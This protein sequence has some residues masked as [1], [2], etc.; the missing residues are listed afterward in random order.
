VHATDP[1][2]AS[3]TLLYNLATGGWD[4]VL[5]G[6]FGVP[7]SMLPGVVPSSGVLAETDADLFGRAVPIAGI[8]GDQQAA[9][10]GQG[11]VTPGDA[12]NTYGT[13][14]FLLVYTGDAPPSP[15]P[16]LLATAACGPGGR[17]GFALE[18]SVFIAGA[19]MQ[20]LRDGLGL[21]ERASDSE[22]LARSVPDTGGVH[23]VPAF[24]GLGSP[25]WEPEARG[26]ITGITRG[27][28]A[29]H[30]VRA[31]L[32]AMAFSS[33]DLLEA[34][35]ASASLRLTH[36]RVDGGATSN[37]W[38]MQFQ[39][40][41][42]GV[43][44]ERPDIVETTALGAACLA[45]LAMGVWPSIEAFT[46]TRRFTRFEPRS[47]PAERARRIAEWRRAVGAAL[48]WARPPGSGTGGAGRRTIALPG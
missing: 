28:T 8:A 35:L 18:G 47:S 34:M 43:P 25:H 6:L 46:A 19:A 30:L 11:C 3:R 42:L 45:G 17:A 32:E 15:G 20:W 33:S 37:D 48:H 9:L 41:L 31:G 1:T 14:A 7:V 12:K 24:V 5:T 23:F 22:A 21:L 10:F 29:A 40:D 38:L 26:T 4:P 2:N 16:G 13:G 44:V 39:A 36:F 27:T